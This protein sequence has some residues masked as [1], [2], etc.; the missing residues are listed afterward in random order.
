MMTAGVTLPSLVKPSGEPD[1]GSKQMLIQRKV[2][3]CLSQAWSKLSEAAQMSERVIEAGE[4]RINLNSRTAEVR[5]RELR[6]SAAEFEV[7]VFLISHKKHFVTKRTTL[8]TKSL[9]GRVT[10]SE[11]LPALVS[12]RKKLQEEV[13]GAQYVRTEAWILYDFQP[14]Y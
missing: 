12:L 2:Q 13:P 10:Q 11:F 3:K 9:D 1:A 8:A 4:F 14:G 6:L 7:L 5:G